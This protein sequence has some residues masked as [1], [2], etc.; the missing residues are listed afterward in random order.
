MV[1]LQANFNLFPKVVK[2]SA[3]QLET[4]TVGAAFDQSV[5]IE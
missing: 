4:F 1:T 2:L 5:S 3:N